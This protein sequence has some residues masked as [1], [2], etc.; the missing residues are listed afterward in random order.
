MSY[1]DKVDQ[2]AKSDAAGI[3]EKDAAY[4]GSWKKRGG[5]GAF[6]MLA[7]KWDRIELAVQEN[8]WD[9]F[10]TI[11]NDHRE[12]TIFDD[13]RDLRRYLNLV[14][15]EI[16]DRI[17]TKE[18]E[19][20]VDNLR[21]DRATSLEVTQGVDGVRRVEQVEKE[22][23]REITPT[24]KFHRGQGGTTL[25]FHAGSCKDAGCPG[26]SPDGRLRAIPYNGGQDYP[27]G[28]GPSI[29]DAQ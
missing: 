17:D 11:T 4:G 18:K 10:V 28:I 19:R 20:A 22:R 26:E 16:L 14:E 21:A 7:R 6:M 9:V 24:P 8:D 12:E 2:V 25:K 3:K 1:I 27:V 13:I 15:A 29:G 23:A 5:V